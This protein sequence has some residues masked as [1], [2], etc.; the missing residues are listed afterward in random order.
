MQFDK[1]VEKILENTL[2]DIA[3]VNTLGQKQLVRNISNDPKKLL[4]FIKG[5]PGMYGDLLSGR[6]EQLNQKFLKHGVDYAKIVD[7]VNA[8]R[9]LAN[10]EQAGQK[11]PVRKALPVSE[12]VS[13]QTIVD[14][15]F[16]DL[17]NETNDRLLMDKIRQRIETPEVK[18]A[19][20]SAFSG[21]LVERL[22]MYIKSRRTKVS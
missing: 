7:G 6:M 22:F 21:D 17:Y 12:N 10:K 4:D 1:T 9:E 13:A 14:Y 5:I 18:K 11:V 8:A 3:T 15:Y 19:F 20:G 16:E 2:Q